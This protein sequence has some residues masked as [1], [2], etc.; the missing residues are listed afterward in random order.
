MHAAVWRTKQEALDDFCRLMSTHEARMGGS[1]PYR[2]EHITLVEWRPELE[3]ITYH[4]IED[5][6]PILIGLMWDIKGMFIPCP[7]L[8]EVEG[9]PARTLMIR[10]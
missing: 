2:L 1:E 3:L 8:N 7:V 9:V 10:V 4:I 5:N 6:A